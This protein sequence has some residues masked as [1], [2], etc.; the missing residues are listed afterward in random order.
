M[1]ATLKPGK[2]LLPSDPEFHRARS[3]LWSRQQSDV[4]PQCIFQPEN[5]ADVA[6]VVTTAKNFAVPFAIKS[7][8][9]AAWTGASSS[10][11][12]LIDLA[13]LNH[14]K[15][16]KDGDAVHVGPGNR[17]VDVYTAL[18]PLGITVIGGRDAD[19]GVGGLIL[20]GMC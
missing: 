1:L 11:G 15:L 16:S 10:T 8:G 19:V 3:G 7:G 9:H 20:G 12:I 14:V 18:E 5:A 2:V 4:I 17:W 6:L 13:K